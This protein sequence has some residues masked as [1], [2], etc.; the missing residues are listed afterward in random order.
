MRYSESNIEDWDFRHCG[1]DDP[2]YNSEGDLFFGSHF[3]TAVAVDAMRVM[4]I[5]TLIEKGIATVEED[6][7]SVRLIPQGDGILRGW[8]S[9]TSRFSRDGR[10]ERKVVDALR[11]ENRKYGRLRVTILPPL[12]GLRANQSD[13]GDAREE[14]IAIDIEARDKAFYDF[15][16]AVG[17]YQPLVAL[18]QEHA[19]NTGVALAND[20]AML[21]IEGWHQSG[22][23]RSMSIGEYLDEAWQALDEHGA[24]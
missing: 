20:E 9:G 14:T 16:N 2:E 10:F 13:D 11:R 3:T 5:T 15:V 6:R 23:V 7:R 24:D 8:K 12:P 19:A 4:V 22:V 17:G 21:M 1:H 18:V